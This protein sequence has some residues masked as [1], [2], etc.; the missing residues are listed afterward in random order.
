M[1]KPKIYIE[2]SVWNQL[3]HDDRPDW[4]EQ[5]IDFFQTVM[6][7]QYDIFISE[8]VEAE[9]GMAQENLISQLK[10][11]INKYK[12]SVLELSDEAINLAEQYLKSIFIGSSKINIENDAYH[13]AIA[14]VEEMDWL[15]S[16]NY[17]HLLKAKNIELFNSINMANGYHKQLNITVPT[18]LI[19]LEE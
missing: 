11:A 13:A 3:F 8:V 14:T 1:K 19:D 17:R 10:G 15:L 4:K 9:I 16:F 6:K 12:P 18:L 2:T 7:R 5:S